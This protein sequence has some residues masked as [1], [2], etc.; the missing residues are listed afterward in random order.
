LRLLGRPQEGLALIDAWIAGHKADADDEAAPDRNWILD[1][2]A[3]TLSALGRYDDTTA[4]GREAAALEEDGQLNVS[5]TINLAERLEEQGKPQAALDVLA[6]F[7]EG[8]PRASVY[9]MMWV[10]TERACALGQLGRTPATSPDL[11]AAL[12]YSAEHLD[13][14]P[15]ARAE[16]LLCVVDLDGAAAAYIARLKDP[17]QRADALMA[18]STWKRPPQP[19][20]LAQILA[21]LDKVR[22]RP[23]VK[24]AV[25]AVGRTE[26][27]PLAGGL[28][29]F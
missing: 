21:R 5:Q 23:D 2:R 28:V 29:T 12:A 18:L 3:E 10:W 16:T 19:V 1:E 26:A 6:V 27:I 24:A 17:E 7:K 9:G 14:N 8:G 15:P 13:S 25:A 4:A 22:A 11:A 20:F